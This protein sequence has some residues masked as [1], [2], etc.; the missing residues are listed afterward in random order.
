MKSVEVIVDAR[1]VITIEATGFKGNACEKATKAIEDALGVV[2]KRE[3]KP[4]YHQQ[5]TGTAT[6]R[7]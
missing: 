3:K 4:E 5:Q 2:A 1:G 7:T 6:Q